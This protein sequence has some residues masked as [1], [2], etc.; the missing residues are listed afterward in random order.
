MHIASPQYTYPHPFD[1]SI[2]KKLYKKIKIVQC[3]NKIYNLYSRNIKK[4]D[5]IVFFSRFALSL[6]I[7]VC[8]CRYLFLTQPKI[9]K[10]KWGRSR[11]SQKLAFFACL[12]CECEERIVQAVH[13]ETVHAC[14][15]Y[16][17]YICT[18]A[19]A[20]RIDRKPLRYA[21]RCKFHV[22]IEYTHANTNT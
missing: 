5:C 13:T 4:I 21:P 14:C 7:S 3:C 17:K 22:F 11:K 16:N 8:L 6:P 10:M 18:H 20:K 9:N 15:M 2:R 19:R 1:Y 12:L